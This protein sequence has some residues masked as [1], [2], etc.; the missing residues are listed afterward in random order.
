MQN[1]EIKL[2]DTINCPRAIITELPF[3]CDRISLVDEKLRPTR[4]TVR[5]R[6][7]EGYTVSE[8]M[9]LICKLIANKTTDAA[10]LKHNN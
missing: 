1:P 9:S 6:K 10:M 3:P 7:R 5:Y 8:D 4:I 2:S